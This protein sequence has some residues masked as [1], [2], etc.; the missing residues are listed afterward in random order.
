MIHDLYMMMHDVCMMMDKILY[1]ILT[2]ELWG[3]G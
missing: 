3:V 2:P 1:M